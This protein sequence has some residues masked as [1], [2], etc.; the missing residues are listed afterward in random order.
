MASIKKFHLPD[1]RGNDCDCLWVLDYRPLGLSGPRRRV[2][3]KTR[4][5]AERFLIET[6][7]KVT[8]GEYVDPAKVPTF[9]EVAE[10]WFRSKTD[11]RPSHV[12]S[13][14]SRIDKYLLPAFGAKRMDAIAVAD[15]E[16]LRDDLRTQNY[17]SST[18]NQI[19]RIASA[20]FRLAVRRGQCSTNLLDRVDRAQ[21]PAREIKPDDDRGDVLS[22]ESILDPCE[23]RRLLDAANAGLDRTL[24]LIA[25]VT[26][27][28][29]GEL[30]ALRWADLEL[31]TTGPGRVYIRR[32]LQWAHLKGEVIRPRFYPP[33]TKAGLRAIS[34]PA[35]LAAALKR[36]KL[37]CPPS[38]L[39]LVF[40][41]EDGRPMRWDHLLRCR[42]YP[43]LARARLRRVTFH[44][45]RHSC[46]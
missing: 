11:R 39:D 29:Q 46:A 34:I 40:P 38:G 10:D 23:I 20:V 13:L 33:K 16:K 37:Q 7:H 12:S 35:E 1:C 30:L 44:S 26:G 5:R 18:V 4:K 6:G 9:S 21:K 27:A 28:R 15:F 25:F 22:P 41:M 31:P 42:F 32:S 36:W 45:L 2:R 17:A 24:F 43:A 19:L 14:R 8:R 3:F